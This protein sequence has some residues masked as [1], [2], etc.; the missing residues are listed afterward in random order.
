MKTRAILYIRVSTDEQTNGYSPAD[1][2]ERLIKH[3]QKNDIEIVSIS[4]EDESAKDFLHRPEWQN[5]L[6]FLK[7]NKNSVDII[8]FAK[9]DRF[10]RNVAE[11]YIT[12]RE[13]KKYNV[14]PQAMEQP[15]DFSIP[16]SKIMLAVYLAAPEVDNDRRALNTFNGMR[17]AKKEGYWV[18]RPIVGYKRFT[19]ENKKPLMVLEG[20]IKEAQ[21]RKVFTEFATGLYTMEQLRRKM[22]K[23]GLKISRTCFPD[24]LKNKAYIGKIFIPAYKDDVAHWID[25]KHEPLISEDVFYK[26]QDILT[27]RVTN[28]PSKYTTKREELPLRGFLTCPKCGK[29]LTGSA[30]KG[31]NGKFF[32]YHCNRGCGE[33]Q[34]ARE[35]NVNFVAILELLRFNKNGIGLLGEVLKQELKLNSKDTKMEVSKINYEIQK[36]NTRLKNARELMLDGELSAKE[37]KEMK[38]EIEE[39]LRA[40]TRLQYQLTLTDE[41]LSEQIDFCVALLSNIDQIYNV[42]DIEAKQQI[43]GSVFPEKLIFEKNKCRTATIEDAVALLCFNNKGFNNTKNEKHPINKVLSLQVPRVGLE[44][45]QP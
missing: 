45:T 33:R 37:Y 1:Q 14:E 5:I 35:L 20:G 38:V 4:H 9:W 16:E 34:K 17:K 6:L 12:I 26:V 43:I 30:S 40:L 15:L 23:E 24:I 3:C 11:A 18:T 25:A 41:N 21:M 7:K 32:Y 31:R 29:N 42:A 13:L 10:S 28:L 2:E 22:Y 19:D 36:Q 44:P 27:G 39:E 8:L